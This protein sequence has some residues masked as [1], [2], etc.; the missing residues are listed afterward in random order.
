MGETLGI[1]D[2]ASL[3]EWLEDQ[4]REVAVWI[5]SRA[6]ARVLPIWWQAVLTEDWANEANLTVLPALRR[7]LTSSVSFHNPSDSLRIAA[8]RTLEG[9]IVGIPFKPPLEADGAA[10]GAALAASA[11]TAAHPAAVAAFAASRA[12]SGAQIGLKSDAIFLA[13][14]ELPD[15][16]PL[17]PEE[18]GPPAEQWR[19]IKWQVDQSEGAEDWQ[20]WIKWYDA[21]LDGRP[22][23]GDAGAD[24]PH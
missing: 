11:A 9:G 10:R 5:A 13:S 3:K 21:L 1:R 23:L 15:D 7:L 20:F 4:P 8:K 22:M 6:A 14:G 17:W 24:R 16:L 12:S 19:A 2:Q 18:A